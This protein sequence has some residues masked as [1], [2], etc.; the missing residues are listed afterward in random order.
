MSGLSSGCSEEVQ[1]AIR[2][3]RPSKTA[4]GAREAGS[5]RAAGVMGARAY[6]GWV[7]VLFIGAEGRDQSA[8]GRMRHAN[9]RRKLSPVALRRA[10]NVE[11]K[12]FQRPGS[13]LRLM[14]GPARGSGPVPA[15]AWAAGP[16]GCLKPRRCSPEP[17]G[18]C[19]GEAQGTVLAA[20]CVRNAVGEPVAAGRGQEDKAGTIDADGAAQRRSGVVGATGRPAVAAP[21]L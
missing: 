11:S 19:P 15:S 8:L 14:A 17:S 20:G 3:G 21:C 7:D 2:R 16:Q 13:G 18:A 1:Q 12:L 10:S 9:G 4:R 6:P 5:G